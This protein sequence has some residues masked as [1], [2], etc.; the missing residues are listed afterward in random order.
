MFA[1]LVVLKTSNTYSPV[2]KQLMVLISLG[3]KE[4]LSIVWRMVKLD[5][6]V[7]TLLSIN[8]FNIWTLSIIRF[9][10]AQVLC[11]HEKKLYAL[12]FRCQDVFIILILFVSVTML[13]RSCSSILC[14]CNNNISIRRKICWGNI[15]CM[16]TLRLAMISVLSLISFTCVTIYHLKRLQVLCYHLKK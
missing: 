10:V 12:T 2:R 9:P 7:V 6:T 13:H 1:H 11:H 4:T 15:S 14:S 3:E 16:T 5:E 8:L